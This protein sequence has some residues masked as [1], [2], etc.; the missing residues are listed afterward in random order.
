MAKTLARKR[1][2]SATIK[3]D[4]NVRCQR[5]YPVEETAKKVA[6][7]KTV[8]LKLTPDQAIHLARV[9]LAVARGWKEIDITPYRFERRK[10]EESYQITVTSPT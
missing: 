8:G 2:S 5:I 7:L 3:V 1:R 9:L 10:S 4:S 6:D